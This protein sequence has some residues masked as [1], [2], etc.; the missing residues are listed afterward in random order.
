MIFQRGDIYSPNGYIEMNLYYAEN[1]QRCIYNSFKWSCISRVVIVLLLV[2]HLCILLWLTV[3]NVVVLTP[4]CQTLMQ[5][6]MRPGL[7]IIVRMSQIEISSLMPFVWMVLH[8]YHSHMEP[9]WPNRSRTGFRSPITSQPLS[10]LPHE[11]WLYV[12]R[13]GHMTTRV[14][15]HSTSSLQLTF[16]FFF[17]VHLLFIRQLFVRDFSQ[18]FVVSGLRSESANGLSLKRLSGENRT[19][20]EVVIENVWFIRNRWWGVASKHEKKH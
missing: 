19:H 6:H 9:V 3:P 8:F 5:A 10:Y 2:V 11:L 4:G 15:P 17:S 7:I 12:S 14:L 20:M 18:T 13:M 1:H 16:S